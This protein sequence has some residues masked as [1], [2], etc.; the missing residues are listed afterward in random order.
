MDDDELAF[1]SAAVLADLVRRRELSPTEI[2]Q[3]VLDRAE[4][5]QPDLNAF[6]TI[7][8]EQALADAQAAERMLMAG[9]ELG[10]LHGVPFTVKDLIDTAGVR[11]TYGSLILENNVPREDG[12]AVARMKASGAIMIAK[13]TTPE[14]G[15]NPM[16]EAPLFGA[17]RNPWDL[18]RTPGGS[19]G[20]SAAAVAAGIAPLSI[21]TDAGGSIRIPA[22][23]CGIVGLKATLGCIPHDTAPDTF[24]SF[25]NQGPMTRTVMDAALMMQSMAGAHPADVHSHGLPGI[26]YVDAAAGQ[27]DLSGLRVAYRPLMGNRIVDPEIVAATED[28][29]G[30]LESLGARVDRVNEDFENTEPYW[31]VITQS[32]WVARFEG[33]LETWRDRMTPTLVQGIDEGREYSAVDLQRAIVFRTKLFRQVQ[34]WFG[35]YDLLITPTLARTALNV[36]HDFAA[37]VEICGEPTGKVRQHWYPYTHPFNMT[38]HPAITLPA[39]LHSDGLPM[40]VQLVGPLSSEALLLRA[41]ALFEQARPW[42]AHRPP[43]TG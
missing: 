22:A 23:C 21:G 20:G 1:T 36:D 29:V 16:T 8:H 35:D 43:E 24:G 18:S 3:R 32:L 7:A 17:T 37:A 34:G 10:P 25:S 31:L 15:H 40:A 13:V 26:D 39:G 11:T 14:F 42:A 30:V 5:S 9:D 41:A 38:G 12:P 33:W 6:I 27:G 2:V 4:A 19:S 28:A